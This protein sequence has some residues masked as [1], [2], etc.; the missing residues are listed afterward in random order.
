VRGA[1][2]SSLP[3]MLMS[4][5]MI[6][7]AV[8]HLCLTEGWLPG[9]EDVARVYEQS[10][11][12]RQCAC[13][14]HKHYSVFDGDHEASA[15]PQQGAGRHDE[16]AISVELR[17]LSSGRALVVAIACRYHATLF[18]CSG[19]NIRIPSQS[20]AEC[21]FLP[22][23][24]EGTKSRQNRQLPIDMPRELL[25]SSVFNVGLLPPA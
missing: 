5:C 7:P 1:W 18:I 15:C 4:C 22:H 20:C 9:G 25:I 2:P 21:P 16:K 24:A 10:V 23:Q 11:A 14:F 13:G 19:L 3:V 12:D 8:E 6:H 17:K